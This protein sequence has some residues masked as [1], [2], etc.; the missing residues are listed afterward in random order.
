MP[1]NETKNGTKS[2]D[3]M[4]VNSSKSGNEK[5]KQKRTTNA[6]RKTGKVN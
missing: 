4:P 2:T 5:D 1:Y 6:S 3:K